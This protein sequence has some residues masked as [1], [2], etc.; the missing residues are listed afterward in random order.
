MKVPNDPLSWFNRG[1]KINDELRQLSPERVEE[2]RR[3]ISFIQ[4]HEKLKNDENKGYLTHKDSE[5]LKQLNIADEKYT[6]LLKQIEGLN[7]SQ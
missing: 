1:L 4:R 7:T 5:D 2:V 3:I 6:D